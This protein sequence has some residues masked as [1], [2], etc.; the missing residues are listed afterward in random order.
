MISSS[1][2]RNSAVASAV[3]PVKKSLGPASEMEL[4]RG[5]GCQV[6]DVQLRDLMQV[7]ENRRPMKPY[8]PFRSEIH[9][10]WNLPASLEHEHS[11]LSHGATQ[12]FQSIDVLIIVKALDIVRKV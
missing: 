6:E 11:S 3:H 5:V 2:S 12:R 1:D 8:L 10:I 4:T 9:V 7:R